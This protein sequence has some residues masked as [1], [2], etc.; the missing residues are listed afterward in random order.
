MVWSFSSAV[1]YLQGRLW[2]QL[3]LC[4]WLRCL[5]ASAFGEELGDDE[6]GRDVAAQVLA[7]K[8]P[9]TVGASLLNRVYG[10]G[11]VPEFNAQLAFPWEKKI[12]AYGD[13]AVF[14]VTQKL[15]GVRALIEVDR[16]RVVAV[17]SRKGKPIR[18]L[19]E[20]EVAAAAVVPASGGA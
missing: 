15:D 3:I 17:H 5:R 8:W 6:R 13:D 20:V 9:L 7:K 1:L 16:G 11:F 2:A 19:V 18:G 12:S 4:R 14:I 10:P